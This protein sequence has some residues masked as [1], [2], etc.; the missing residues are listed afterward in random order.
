MKPLGLSYA[1]YAWLAVP[2]AFLGLPL[3]LN[4]PKF[5]LE[6]YQVD[7]STLGIVLLCLRLGDA[8]LDPL[9]GRLSDRYA[10]YR[11][12]IFIAA[13]GLCVVSF[14]M[15]FVAPQFSPL[16]WFIVFT[17]LTYF[18]YSILTINY[19]SV[20]LSQAAEYNQRTVLSA[21]REGAALVGTLLAAL[22]PQL[23]Q[24]HFTA[25][26][27]FQIYGAIF[28]VFVAF[29]MVHLLPRVTKTSVIAGPHISLVALLKRN[30]K[31]SWLLG[32]FFF[33]ALPTAITST[34]FLFYADDVLHAKDSAGYFLAVYF[35]AAV[36]SAPC[37]S[38]LSQKIGKRTS[39][40]AGMSLA[41]AS[42]VWAYTL[43]QG[44]A[45]KFYMICV[46]SGFAIG[47]DMILLP[48]LLA[49]VLEGQDAHGSTGFGLW[50]ALSKWSL[51]LAAGIS[52]PLLDVY[53]YHPNSL[54]EPSTQGIVSIA[55]ALIPCGIKL[56]ALSILLLSPLDQPQPR[57]PI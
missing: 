14:N 13:A 17:A 50:H 56:I 52:L 30:A 32:L 21:W 25:L 24:S 12:T 57:K 38:Y 6:Q 51:A 45:D 8:F 29:G 33:N 40:I 1:G 23:L 11:R 7:L 54:Q 22:L 39:L 27:G 16:I 41:M 28:A 20:G 15:L 49:D 9:I 47:A 3:Y 44:D 5:Y 43:G 53:G 48:S 31:L 18:S 19:Y 35:F 55:Y 26:H 10:Q 4:L 37:W 36:L 46:L 34:L 2:L 42:F